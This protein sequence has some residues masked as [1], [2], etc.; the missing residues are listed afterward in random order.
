MAK[1]LPILIVFL[2]FY[3]IA[4]S[5]YVR[6]VEDDWYYPSRFVVPLVGMLFAEVLLFMAIAV[7]IVEVI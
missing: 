3:I 1:I 6:C 2:V 4:R 7:H 5:E